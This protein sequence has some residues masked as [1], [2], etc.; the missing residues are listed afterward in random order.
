MLFFI[1]KC[2]YLCGM[3]VTVHMSEDKFP[4]MSSPTMCG[5]NTETHQ[6]MNG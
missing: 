4:E 1:F 3:P 2:V 6:L 5:I